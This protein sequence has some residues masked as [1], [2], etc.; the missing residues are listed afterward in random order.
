MKI[1]S[2][3]MNLNASSTI[4][5]SIK[6][7][8][9]RS[10]IRSSLWD[11]NNFTNVRELL[12]NEKRQVKTFIGQPKFNYETDTSQAEEFFSKND[13]LQ[14]SK[15]F[16]KIDLYDLEEQKSVNKFYLAMLLIQFLV[17]PDTDIFSFTQQ[18]L[19]NYEFIVNKVKHSV[20]ISHKEKLTFSSTGKIQTSDGRTIDLHMNFFKQ[21]EKIEELSKTSISTEIIPMCDPLVINLDVPCAGLSDMTADFDLT[22]DGDTQ[23]FHFPISGSGFLALDKNGDNKI[24]DGSELFGT[25]S[26]DGFKDL[27]KYDD[28]GSSWIDE[29]DIVFSRLKVWTKDKDGTDKL[30]ALADAKVGAIYLGSADADFALRDNSYDNL[31]QIRK[32]GIFLKENGQAGTMQHVDVA[33]A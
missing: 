10:T 4:A 31:G 6:F 29:N 26:G 28:D 25:K 5:D 3:I 19:V 9:S 8:K 13:A 15:N 18:N 21:T 27:A 33:L 30:I 12:D 14:D 24:N 20:Q 17:G 2:S 22:Q 32:T 16:R 11:K 7:K 23:K 1:K